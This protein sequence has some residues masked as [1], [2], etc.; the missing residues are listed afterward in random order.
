[1]E[2][3][4]TTMMERKSDNG[5][6]RRSEETEQKGDNSCERRSE[7]KEQE[8]EGRKVFFTKDK[9]DN[10]GQKSTARLKPPQ[11]K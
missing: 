5:C 10:N 8:G 3:T 11:Q 1:M 7:E 9:Y 4:M 2:T 6:E